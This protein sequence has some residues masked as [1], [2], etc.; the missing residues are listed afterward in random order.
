M[1]GDEQSRRCDARPVDGESGDQLSV[2]GGGLPVDAVPADADEEEAA[3]IAVALSAYLAERDA[4]HDDDEAD[5]WEG[6]R[7]AFAGRMRG[8]TG[9]A[10]RISTRA[11]TDDWTAAD[12][13]DRL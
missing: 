4:E 3:A 6:R 2:V 13:A 7:W 10:V 1:A 12:R 9:R 11:P 8:L 5:A